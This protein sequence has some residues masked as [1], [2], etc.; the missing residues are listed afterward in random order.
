MTRILRRSF[1]SNARK[2]EGCIPLSS[3]CDKRDK[4][5]ITWFWFDSGVPCTWSELLKTITSAKVAIV[6][7]ICFPKPTKLTILIAWIEPPHNTR[8]TQLDRRFFWFLFDYSYSIF[9]FG[10]QFVFVVYRSF[11]LFQRP[12]IKCKW[13]N[14]WLRTFC[15]ACHLIRTQF[16][17][18]WK[19]RDQPDLLLR[20]CHFF[21]H[22]LNVADTLK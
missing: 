7:W 18:A 22:Q 6:W 13:I 4:F 14:E 5:S 15:I 1:T 12:R 17:W 19:P 3:F 20:L 2:R 11:W 16:L 10:S 8:R 21:G 9:F